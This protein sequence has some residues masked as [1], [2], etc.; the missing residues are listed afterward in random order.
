[1]QKPIYENK[2]RDIKELQN[3]VNNRKAIEEIVTTIPG[4]TLKSAMLVEDQNFEF[5]PML[6]IYAKDKQGIDVVLLF[7]RF[8]VTK[9]KHGSHTPAHTLAHGGEPIIALTSAF[10]TKMIDVNSD[11]FST[12]ALKYREKAITLLE[13]QLEEMKKEECETENEKRFH[14]RMLSDIENTI[15]AHKQI[16]TNIKGHI[17]NSE[18]N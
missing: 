14:Y 11:T 12:D 2:E 7:N 8:G 13:R 15:N 1:M 17:N 5:I 6:M 3:L 10:Q 4:Y 16:L 18:R 9:I